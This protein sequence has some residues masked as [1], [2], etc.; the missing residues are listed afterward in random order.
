MAI[1]DQATRR[2][3]RSRA[4][5]RASSR[6]RSRASTGRVLGGI[7]TR[8]EV[9]ELSGS[10]QRT[11]EP[12]RTGR[13][14][15]Q[16]DQLALVASLIEAGV[17]VDVAFDTLATVGGTRAT[18]EA[19]SHVRDAL[20]RGRTIADALDEVGAPDHVRALIHGGERVGQ[21]VP[22][23]RAASDLVR[24]LATL[25][26]DLKRALVYPS[27]VLTLGIG[28]LVIVALVV[29][30]PLERTFDDLGGELPAATRAVLAV[31][32]PLRS[33]FLLT[34]IVAMVGLS[35]MLRQGRWQR[36]L[37]PWSSI[38]SVP[39]MRGLRAHVGLSVAARQIATMLA[40][41]I[42]LID[43]L[44]IAQESL[45]GSPLTIRLRAAIRAVES[46]GSALADDALG[47]A[48]DPA[49]REILAVGERT[50][51]LAEQW[52]RVAVR[53]AEDLSARI[54]RLGVIVEP[55]LVVLVGA[56]VGGAVL[57]LYLPTF[58]VLDLL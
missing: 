52:E 15:P 51:M 35:L 56:L 3:G 6:I 47:G 25:T 57:A 4:T 5:R 32:R 28:I 10:D 1:D 12:V 45:R 22:A 36:R 41:G 24:R 18:R 17:T 53:R 30:P 27:V 19:A 49:E 54:G 50:G 21:V 33:P 37:P 20:R 8:P 11:R 58:R 48:L 13:W 31:S 39:L 7:G 55:L 44:R 29:V 42:P 43:A 2:V 23:L 40:G 9:D 46:G 38:A 26:A 14:V 16:P 34:A